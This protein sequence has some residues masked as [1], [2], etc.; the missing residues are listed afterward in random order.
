MSNDQTMKYNYARRVFRNNE[1]PKF[2]T[3]SNRSIIDIRLEAGINKSFAWIL[4]SFIYVIIGKVHSLFRKSTFSILRNV[5]A[6]TR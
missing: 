4:F 5:T 2:D 1:P 6:G 3:I